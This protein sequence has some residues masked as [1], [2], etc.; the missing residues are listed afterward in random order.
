MRKITLFMSTSLDGFIGGADDE[1]T[2]DASAQE[3]HLFANQLFASADTVL[4]G[5]TTYEGFTGY[6][7]T[8]DMTDA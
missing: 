1:D 7:D 6:W 8:L 5:R 4:F 3:D 2:A